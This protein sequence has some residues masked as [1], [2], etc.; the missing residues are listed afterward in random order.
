MKIKTNPQLNL[1]INTYNYMS[2][3]NIIQADKKSPNPSSNIGSLFDDM[4]HSV[5]LRKI[6]LNPKTAKK[7]EITKNI[8]QLIFLTRKISVELRVKKA[9][10]AMLRCE[11]QTVADEPTKHI[12]ITITLECMQQW[13]DLQDKFPD[14]TSSEIF[15]ALVTKYEEN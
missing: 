15:S 13:K 11:L 4:L 14:A 2:W 3:N 6:A 9:E 8:Q 1:H 12:N 7:R 10:L 5:K